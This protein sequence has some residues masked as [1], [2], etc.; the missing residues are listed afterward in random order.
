[1]SVPEKEKRK[2]ATYSFYY[3]CFDIIAGKTYDENMKNILNRNIKKSSY[4]KNLRSYF[5][6]T[7]NESSVNLYVDQ[8]RFQKILMSFPTVC[9]HSCNFVNKYKYLISLN[10]CSSIL[11]YLAK[12]KSFV[13]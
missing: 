13:E 7:I 5:M 12:M 9:I 8:K 1:M 10:L 3:K 11:K 2:R 6:Y 4:L